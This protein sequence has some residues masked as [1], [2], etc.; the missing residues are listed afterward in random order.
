MGCSVSHRLLSRMEHWYRVIN[1]CPEISLSSSC[2]CNLSFLAMS[3]PFSRSDV[4]VLIATAAAGTRGIWKWNEK[5]LGF[6]YRFAVLQ[7]Q[8]KRCLRQFLWR[9]KLGSVFLIDFQYLGRGYRAEKGKVR[10]PTNQNTDY[11]ISWQPEQFC[12][13]KFSDF[14]LFL[15]FS[16]FY[17]NGNNPC[18]SKSM[19]NTNKP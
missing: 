18:D 9:E 17:T 3:H 11:C 14:F 5:S 13:I 10:E 12:K 2:N 6:T 1:T 7:E 15:V 19:C 8:L 4:R 16:C